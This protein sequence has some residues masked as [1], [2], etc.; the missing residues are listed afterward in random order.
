MYIFY[1]VSFGKFSCFIENMF[2]YLPDWKL[3]VPKVHKG[4]FNIF[5]AKSET[6]I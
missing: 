5:L 4:D 1:Y 6:Y 3:S 2:K